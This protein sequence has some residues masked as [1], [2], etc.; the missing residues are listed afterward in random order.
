LIYSYLLD[1]TRTHRSDYEAGLTF[2]RKD[3]ITIIHHLT[4]E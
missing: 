1:Q 3:W 2:D 4:S